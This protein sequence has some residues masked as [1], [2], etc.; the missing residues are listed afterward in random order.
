M[1]VVVI[2][3]KPLV[4]VMGLVLLAAVFWDN[5]EQIVQAVTKSLKPIYCVKTDTKQIALTFDISWGE[6]NVQPILDVLK[7]EEIKA[8]FFLSSPWAES[9]PELVQKIKADGHE[10]GSHGRRHV[11]LNHLGASELSSEL[12][13]SK[14]VLEKITGQ[15]ISLL[16]PP[17]GAYDNDVISIANQKG[18]KVIQWSVDSLDWQ[19]P[20]P[21]AIV[22][23]ILSGRRSNKGASPGDILL[24]HASDSAP[25]TAQALP[26][27]I[28][29]LKE[30]GYEPVPVGT[31]L[32]NA[33]E[34]WPPGSSL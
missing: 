23:N 32:Q 7:K 24:F 17:N 20:G 4:L 29:A 1:A 5:R 6:K 15:K 22:R 8:T 31:L 11:D 2:K 19:R 28:K 30:K 21:D 33:N 13:I 34:S 16:R 9:K 27:I 10:I 14:N 18:Y 3:K 12:D 25:D 26:V